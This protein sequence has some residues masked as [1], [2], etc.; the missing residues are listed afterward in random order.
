MTTKQDDRP[1]HLIVLENG[2]LSKYLLRAPWWSDSPRLQDK[3]GYVTLTHK[4]L[5][6]WAHVCRAALEQADRMPTGEPKHWRRHHLPSLLARAERR[7]KE[8]GF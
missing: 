6:S 5:M 8:A 2:R 4:E 7:K 3:G 1:W